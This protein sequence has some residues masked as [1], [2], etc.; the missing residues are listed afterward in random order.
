MAARRGFYLRSAAQPRAEDNEPARP[1]TRVGRVEGARTEGL[2]VERDGFARARA[3][4][5]EESGRGVVDVDGAAYLKPVVVADCDFG[6]A[7]R[8][9]VRH[10]KAYLSRRGV[11]D[12]RGAAFDADRHV[13]EIRGE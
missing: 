9:A 1:A 13:L 11:E 5:R 7:R 12:L 4:G 6:L 3:V 10:E 8:E 2:V